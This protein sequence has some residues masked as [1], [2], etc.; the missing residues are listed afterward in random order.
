MQGA[1][2]EV[3][4]RLSE[5]KTADRQLPRDDRRKAVDPWAAVLGAGEPA[6]TGMK[7]SESRNSRRKSQVCTFTECPLYRAYTACYLVCLY[8]YHETSLLTESQAKLDC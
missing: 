3:A 4:S 2:E 7:R 8:L 5:V 1:P 6:T